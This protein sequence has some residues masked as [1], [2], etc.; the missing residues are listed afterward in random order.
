MWLP[1]AESVSRYRARCNPAHDLGIEH[2]R[3]KRGQWRASWPFRTR[4]FYLLG[5]QIDEARTAADVLLSEKPGPVRSGP[6]EPFCSALPMPPIFQT[7]II[8]AV[9]SLLIM[10]RKGQGMMQLPKESRNL[11]AQS[12][13]RIPHETGAEGLMKERVTQLWK[14]RPFSWTDVTLETPLR[15]KMEGGLSKTD[16]NLQWTCSQHPAPLWIT[17]FV[18][19]SRL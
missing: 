19:H 1:R 15:C 4:L 7:A 12:Q 9:A 8:W 2:V 11:P 18:H 6:S 5:S 17:A 3:G 10:S 13:F 14:C 16:I